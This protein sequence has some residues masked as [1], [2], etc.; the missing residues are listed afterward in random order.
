MTQAPLI[1]AQDF[2]RL[3]AHAETMKRPTHYRLLLILMRD[4]G[5]RPIELARLERSWFRNTE[6]RIPCGQSKRGRARTLPTSPAIREAIEVHMGNRS[7]LLFVN[8]EGSAFTPSQMSASVRRL[9][10]EAGVE[11]STYSARR[12][13][14]TRLVDQDTNILVVQAVL[15]HS[16]PQTTMAYCSVTP[17]MVR[18]ALFG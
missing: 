7:G 3:F 12:A 18:R 17:R 2:V 14:A 13:L 11:G 8:R 5:L 9:F 16:S 10:A 6:L 15:G 4:L 1:E